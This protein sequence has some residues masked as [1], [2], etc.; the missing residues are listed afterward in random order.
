MYGSH[1]LP[2]LVPPPKACWWS[3]KY[4][5][6]GQGRRKGKST[7]S[8]LQPLAFSQSSFRKSKPCRVAV[9]CFYLFLFPCSSES[10]LVPV[11]TFTFSLPCACSENVPLL[12]G[13]NPL[14][15]RALNFKVEPKRLEGGLQ[16]QECVSIAG[17]IDQSCFGRLNWLVF[18]S[19]DKPHLTCS[20]Y[21]SLRWKTSREMTYVWG[22]KNYTSSI[23]ILFP[24]ATCF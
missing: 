6:M 21:F 9:K 10:H 14:W 12:L 24:S 1:L 2:T 13:W 3:P 18:T 20:L 7:A 22:S 19:P 8:V 23:W 5:D 11:I 17:E 15:T 4:L 16:T